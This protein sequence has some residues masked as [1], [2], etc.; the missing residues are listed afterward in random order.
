[1]ALNR[2]IAFVQGQTVD[3]PTVHYR[4]LRG[5]LLSGFDRRFIIVA[6]VSVLLHF[7]LAFVLEKKELPRQKAVVLEKM[8]ERIAK[9][10]VEKPIV[11]TEEK[12]ATKPRLENQNTT[13]EKQVEEAP[14]TKKPAPVKKTVRQQARATEEK[15]RT[16]GVLNMLTGSGETAKGPAVV[17]V[18]G[19]IGK[20]DRKQDLEKALSEL[21]GLQQ[22]SEKSQ[23][24][25]KIVQREEVLLGKRESID[26]LIGDL[27]ENLATQLVKKG[28]FIVRRPDVID[29]AGAADSKRD[30]RTINQM[31]LRNKSNIYRI[32]ERHLKRNP[33][34]QGKVT[35]RFVIAATGEVVQVDVLENS[36]GSEQL[37]QELVAKI[38]SWEFEKIA[39]GEASV[40]YPF[41]FRPT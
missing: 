36:T 31:V 20:K 27:G 34:L 32:Y 38:K 15:V 4:R 26:D 30:T 33:T 40:V 10:I 1:V 16:V 12:K 24:E 11:K 23:V 6:L 5:G 37:E 13:T 18:L 7:A 8:S 17:D 22:V 19:A 21:Q 9:L 3:L 35:I 29:G 25:A 28:E 14:D 2:S 41:V 39:Q